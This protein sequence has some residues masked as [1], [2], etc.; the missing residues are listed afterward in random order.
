[1]ALLLSLSYTLLKLGVLLSLLLLLL[2]MLLLL[3]IADG[4]YVRSLFVYLLSF[5]IVDCCCRWW[6]WWFGGLGYRLHRIG[7]WLWSCRAGLAKR[8][9]RLRF[10]KGLASR[11]GRIGLAGVGPFV[12]TYLVK[13]V[14]T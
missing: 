12:D 9:R 5:F 10:V 13:L 3:G 2:L 7:L 8:R 14:A 1:M 6:L 4:T 11:T